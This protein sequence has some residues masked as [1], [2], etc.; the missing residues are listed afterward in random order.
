MPQDY[1][2]FDLSIDPDPDDDDLFIVTAS[3]LGVS[4]R[5]Y[6]E[7][8]FD[9]LQLE[10]RLDKLKILL[11]KGTRALSLAPA[12][13]VPERERPVRELGVGMFEALLPGELRALYRQAHSHTHQEDLSGVRVRLRINVPQWNTLPWEFMYDPDSE[14]YLGVKRNTPIIRFPEIRNPPPPLRVKGKLRI[15]AM[16]ANP[17][18]PELDKLEV[19]REQERLNH[20]LQAVGASV[21]VGWIRGT[22][23]ALSEALNRGE[24]WHVFHYIGHGGYEERW[25]GGLAFEDER[26]KVKPYHAEYLKNRLTGHPSMRFAFLN[27]CMGATSGKR[28]VFSSTAAT[29]VRGGLAGVLA[30][31]FEV[32][33]KGAIRIADQFYRGLVAGQRLESVVTAAREHVSELGSF[34]WG[35]PVLYLASPNGVLF[36]VEKQPSPPAPLPHAVEGRKTPVGTTQA[37]SAPPSPSVPDPKAIY[38]Q[39]GDLDEAE[40][41]AESIPLYEQLLALKPPYRE[42]TVRT[43]LAQARELLIQQQA[44]ETE[45]TERERIEQ[46]KA[47]RLQAAQERFTDMETLVKRARTDGAKAAAR[48]KIQA[49][50]KDYPEYKDDPQVAALRKQ[51]EVTSPPAPLPQGEGRKPTRPTSIQILPT[52]FAWI[53]I[54][55][56]KVTLKTEKGWSKNYIPEGKT[57]TFDV[58]A[59]EIAKYPLTNAQ[60][61][62]FIKAG[63]YTEAKWWTAAGLEVR[64]AVNWTEPR[65]WQD[66]KW[67]QPDHPVVGVSW[68]EAVAYCLWLSEITGERIHLPTEQEWQRAAQGDTNRAYPYGEKFDKARCNFNTSG[69]TPVTQYEGKDKGDSPF[70]VVDM[71]GNVWEWCVTAYESGTNDLDG[72]DVR[73]LRGGSW[74]DVNE[75]NLRADYRLRSNP[76]GRSDLRGLRLARS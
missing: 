69:T 61:A 1:L 66:S 16:I 63:G 57:Q 71:S 64:K 54:P 39:A 19:E 28:D 15:L 25:G 65:Y 40:R 6:F 37:S 48:E 43:L 52:P 59:F 49:F 26:G 33:D 41:Y 24:R 47:A 27:C 34:E 42:T 23:D 18:D 3:A 50:T 11:S 10:S 21:E 60:F 74:G 20:A 55:A 9:D 32:S 53:K 8:P 70:G 14:C 36:E 67:N 17:D 30:M 62:P 2:D 4:K 12:P 76:Q 73:I 72:T 68:Y 46:E 22:V 75:G 35:T 58:P 5:D 51:V 29:L 13:Q 56:G 7:F 38:D 44:E 45:R 31:Q